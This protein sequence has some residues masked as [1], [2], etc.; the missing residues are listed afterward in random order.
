MV[1]SHTALLEQLESLARLDKLAA[2]L[3]LFLLGQLELRT[4]EVS[5]AVDKYFTLDVDTEE[6]LI[7]A[8][9]LDELSEHEDSLVCELLKSLPCEGVILLFFAGIDNDLFN[10]ILRDDHSHSLCPHVKVKGE[11]LTLLKTA[12]LKGVPPANFHA[13]PEFEVRHGAISAE[14]QHFLLAGGHL[15]ALSALN[16]P[17][18]RLSLP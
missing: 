14:L 16:P 10:L 17:A 2:P 5:H 13:L 3:V 8:G 1:V 9:R 11:S 18:C 12:D 15:A 4:L 6:E 7:A